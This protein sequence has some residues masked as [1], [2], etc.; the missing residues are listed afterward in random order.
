MQILIKDT[1]Y[2]TLWLRSTFHVFLTLKF[3]LDDFSKSFNHVSASSLL[4]SFTLVVLLMWLY[5]SPWVQVILSSM[6]ILEELF[7]S[8]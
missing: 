3:V 8:T 5:F 1:L 4:E 2:M 7:S 6:N